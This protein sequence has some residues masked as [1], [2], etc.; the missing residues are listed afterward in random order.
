MAP[1]RRAFYMTLLAVS[2]TALTYVGMHFFVA[3]RLPVNA[4]EVPPIVGLSPEQARG[5]LEPRGLLLVLDAEKVDDRVPPGTLC[6]Q[7]PLGG[8]RLRRGDLVHAFIGRAGGPHLVPKV[9]GLQV[10]AARQMI[11]DARLKV[12]RI[13]DGPSDTVPRG[14]VAA[15]SPEAGSEVKADTTVDLTLSMG[16]STKEVPKVIGKRLSSAKQ[17]LEQ[18]GFAVGTTKYGSNDDYDQGIVIGQNPIAGAQA[19]PGVKI[20]LTIND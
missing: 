5:L 3:P 6:E 16:P 13:S 1:M 2:A 15:V 12:G 20:D 11:S 7:S 14:L 8:S 10:D 17:L 19:S 18:A 9:V 4:V